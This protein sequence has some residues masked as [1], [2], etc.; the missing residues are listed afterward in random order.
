MA[1]RFIGNSNVTPAVTDD[2][3][4]TK[5]V[6]MFRS[7][8]YIVCALSIAG[9]MG[10]SAQSMESAAS[11][12][13]KS[14]AENM[15]DT[16]V[17]SVEDTPIDANTPVVSTSNNLPVEA[18][19]VPNLLLNL[20]NPAQQQSG[21]FL[22]GLLGGN[23]CGILNTLLSVGASYLTGGNPFVGNLVSGLASSLFKCGASSPLAGLV[24]GGASSKDHLFQL[25][26]QVMN[27][28]TQGQDPTAL[29]NALKNPQDLSGLLS[30]VT[31]LTNQSQSPELIKILSVVQN[32]QTQFQGSIGA[33]GSMNAKAC[34]MF[35][36]LNLVRQQNGLASLIPNSNCTAAAQAHSK[37][38]LS[39]N[40]LSHLS[41]DGTTAK[42]RLAKF[43]VNGAWAENIIRGNS[44][45]SQQ[46]L[47]MLLG[48]A[49]H[50]KNILNPLFTSGGIGFI[51]GYFT[52]CFT[53]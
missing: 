20:M 11:D 50:K 12:Q 27:V 29:L 32:F 45:S 4:K 16:P 26:S 25:L 33:C 5:G 47:E 18:A 14:L 39:N 15:S 44:L 10:C 52:Q 21:G 42:E 28:T 24:P 43:G 3:I 31:S 49:G 17:I 7:L 48:S 53:K 22:G 23:G 51:N 13:Q 37:D 1:E 34:Q 2:D 30:I 35:Q 38:M 8:K 36:I 40:L 19:D 6:F 46:A 9:L 41:S